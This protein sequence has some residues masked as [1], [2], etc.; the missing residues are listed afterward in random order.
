MRADHNSARPHKKPLFP[1]PDTV[2]RDS[3]ALHYNKLVTHT[4]HWARERLQTQWKVHEANGVDSIELR[5]SNTH[6]EN[7]D[8]D[9]TSDHPSK[10]ASVLQ[11]SPS[12]HW[13]INSD[14]SL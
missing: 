12:K 2:I 3:V 4:S 8:A 6:G 5:S 13:E 1:T 7:A 14:N 10:S 11:F 9:Q